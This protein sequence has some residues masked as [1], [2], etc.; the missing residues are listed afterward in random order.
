MENF[1]NYFKSRDFKN[2]QKIKEYLTKLPDFCDEF[3]RGIEHKT[4]YLTRLNYAIDLK[5]FF[6]FLCKEILEFNNKTVKQL[7]LKDLS[8]ITATHIEIFLTY[9]SS[10]YNNDNKYVTNNLSGKA[11]KL[12][13]LRSFLK[14]FYKKDKIISN[15]ASKID[16]P[17]IH[18]KEIIRL[19]V[20]EVVKLLNQAEFP[21]NFSKRQESYNNITKKRDVAILTLLLGTGIR[22]SECVGLNIDDIDFNVNGF[23][24]TR[25]GGNQVVL[26]FSN[27]V[28]NALLDYL[29]ERLNNNKIQEDEKALFI[30]MQN[31]RMTVRSIEKLVKK[32]SEASIPLKHITPHKLRSTYGTNLYKETRDIYIVAD[33]LGHKD[34]NTTKKHYA[35]IS[36]DVRRN[37]A[38]KVKL[39]D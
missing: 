15:V 39:R 16:T 35:A 14:Y 36:E 17:K 2:L 29:E 26:Y 23:K 11:R 19:E 37:I 21:S 24:I 18:T 9:L 10:Y 1:D 5:I 20:D 28:R 33:V 30:S 22:V 3:F 25:K 7:T 13:T 27:E 38:E 34:V 32:Y 6:D 4:T 31:K 12:A 8:K